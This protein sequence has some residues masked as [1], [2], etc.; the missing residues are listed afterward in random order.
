MRS[1]VWDLG[2]KRWLFVIDSV[3]ILSL[4]FSSVSS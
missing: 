1:I 3:A 4:R 2:R